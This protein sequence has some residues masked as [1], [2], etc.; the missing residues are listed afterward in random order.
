[1]P[2]MLIGPH[3]EKRPADPIATNALHVAKLSTGEVDETYV[4]RT[5]QAGG[6]KGGQ[7]RRDSLTLAER[8]LIALRAAKTRW[9]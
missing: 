3:G 8:K 2:I 6:R 7:A 1:M 9:G 4:D 5:K